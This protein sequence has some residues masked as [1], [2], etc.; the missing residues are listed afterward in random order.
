MTSKQPPRRY[1]T[2]PES[3]HAKRA[4]GSKPDDSATP[5]PKTSSARPKKSPPVRR[6]E[7]PD[8]GD[9]EKPPAG[10]SAEAGRK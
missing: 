4:V 1:N 10:L 7:P 8:P 9:E 2:R 5:A 6:T 3:P